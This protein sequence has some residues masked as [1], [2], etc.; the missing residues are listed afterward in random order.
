MLTRQHSCKKAR[1]SG[2]IRVA[3]QMLL[4]VTVNAKVTVVRLLFD[5][6]FDLGKANHALLVPSKYEDAHCGGGRGGVFFSPL[7]VV[8]QTVFPDL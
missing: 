4:R 5:R 6:C 3:S 8:I 7:I 2:P 1:Q